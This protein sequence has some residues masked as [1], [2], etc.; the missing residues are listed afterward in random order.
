MCRSPRICGSSS[1]SGS[2][3]AAAAWI[4]PR[5]SRRVGGIHGSPSRSYTSSSAWATMSSSVS[6]WN[7]PY[8]DS[9]SFLRTAISR[10]RMLCALDPVKYWSAAPH[11][12][13]GTTRRST[14]RP[15]V[16]RMEDLVSTNELVVKASITGTGSA[17]ATSRSMSPMVST[18]LRNDPAYSHRSTCLRP[19]R[20]ARSSSARSRAAPS[21]TRSPD[22]CRSWMPLM[23]FSS[24]LGPNPRTVA[25][26]CSWMASRSSST[27]EMCS[28]SYRAMAFFGP[29]VGIEMSWRTPAG[30]WARSS[31]SAGIEPVWRYSATFSAIDFPTLGMSSS[32]S[33][34]KSRMSAW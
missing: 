17:L 20:S 7:S 10:S 8:S 19:D 9:F 22:C 18:I 34:S 23:M 2:S 31:S 33:R 4:S 25:R 26:R 14:W 30:I 24:V 29:S 13:G 5:S 15:L 12:S 1:T 28:S 16:V 21:C 27:E 11:T 6:A 32:S 3:A